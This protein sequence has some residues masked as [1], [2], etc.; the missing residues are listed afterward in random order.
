MEEN[1]KAFVFEVIIFLKVFT[2]V[3]SHSTYQEKLCWYWIM[4]EETHVL[5][6]TC[7]SLAEFYHS[8]HYMLIVVRFGLLNKILL[9]KYFVP[10]V[11][12]WRL[13]TWEQAAVFCDWPISLPDSSFVASVLALSTPLRLYDQCDIFEKNQFLF[14]QGTTEWSRPITWQ[15]Y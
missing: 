1:S 11:L 15:K 3:F 9:L 2:I 6:D 7:K 4:R 10:F 5:Y 13:G 8:S 12:F 14:F